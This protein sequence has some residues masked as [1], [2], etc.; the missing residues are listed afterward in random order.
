MCWAL[1]LYLFDANTFL[2]A[3]AAL[4]SCIGLLGSLKSCKAKP[5]WL[6][7]VGVSWDAA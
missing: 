3:A 6:L 7:G 1:V 2:V 4:H 5:S